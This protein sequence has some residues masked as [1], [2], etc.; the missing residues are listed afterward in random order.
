MN[1]PRVLVSV[2]LAS[3]I[4]A[5]GCDSGAQNTFAPGDTTP[6]LAKDKGCT[7]DPETDHPSCKPDEP[8][9]D[10]DPDTD[11]MA[12]LT[13]ETV[14]GAGTGIWTPVAQDVE[15]VGPTG[16]VHA[17]SSDK[18]GTNSKP[19]YSLAHFNTKIQLL[20][21][22]ATAENCDYYNGD[23]SDKDA[24]F[25]RMNI[26]TA[27]DVV[28]DVQVGFN[29]DPI[30]LTYFL[31]RWEDNEG[32]WSVFLGRGNDFD[33]NA[34]VAFDGDIADVDNPN[35]ERKF[36]ITG[37]HVVA[38]KGPGPTSKRSKLACHHDNIVEVTL[39]PVV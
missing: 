21:T 12:T 27:F 36:I 32:E 28:F 34:Q 37:G 14:S 23:G 11:G 24:L 25:S 8:D 15:V 3:V 18:Q 39:G 6:L 22:D 20:P 10:P 31:F 7:G 38:T 19:N 5:L 17:Y 30:W 29:A 16:W 9:P 4:F 13:I 2:S 1:F 35:I 26:D 33:V